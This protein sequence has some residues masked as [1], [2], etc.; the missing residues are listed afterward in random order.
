MPYFEVQRKKNSKIR[1][2]I[3]LLGIFYFIYSF[4]SFNLL[5]VGLIKD[6][7][8]VKP[9]SMHIEEKR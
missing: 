1:Y 6:K 4:L 3:A 7:N 9:W 2:S 8:Q 5:R